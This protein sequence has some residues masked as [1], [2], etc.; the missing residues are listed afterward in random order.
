[1]GNLCFECEVIG[2]QL[3]CSSESLEVG[4]FPLDALPQPLLLTHKIRIQ[5]ALTQ[6]DQPYIR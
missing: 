2:G 5:D 3:T 6:A 4:F 1:M